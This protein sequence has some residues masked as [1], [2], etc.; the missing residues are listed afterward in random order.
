MVKIKIY[1]GTVVTL[2]PVCLVEF[3]LFEIFDYRYK[4]VG[5]IS[6]LVEYCD[7]ILNSEAPF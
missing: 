1:N 7:K 6:Y 3:L 4:E 2:G 5:E